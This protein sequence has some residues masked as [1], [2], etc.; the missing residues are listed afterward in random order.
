MSSKANSA[1]IRRR[2]GASA[3]SNITAPTYTTAP[4]T[5]PSPD[6]VHIGDLIVSHDRALAELKRTVAEQAEQI[7]G[8]MEQV[9][10]LTDGSAGVDDAEN[11]NM[12]I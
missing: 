5:S 11:N 2:V 10:E 12:S 6:R 3:V 1:A 8:L 7:A 9:K 4:T